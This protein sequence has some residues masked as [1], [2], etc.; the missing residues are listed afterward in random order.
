MVRVS[1][2]ESK[3]EINTNGN[4]FDVILF[5]KIDTFELFLKH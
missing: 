1:C 4:A 3:N 5:D 2:S